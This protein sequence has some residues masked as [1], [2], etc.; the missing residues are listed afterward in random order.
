M[1]ACAAAI[2]EMAARCRFQWRGIPPPETA[3]ATATLTRGQVM[4]F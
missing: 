2:F 1:D 4:E 3:I